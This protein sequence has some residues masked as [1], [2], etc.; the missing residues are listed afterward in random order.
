MN[1]TQPCGPTVS[2]E[3]RRAYRSGKQSSRNQLS[4]SHRSRS[5]CSGVSS[6]GLLGGSVVHG[7][8][9]WYI[10]SKRTAHTAS[11]SVVIIANV[12]LHLDVIGVTEADILARAVRI[13]F[14]PRRRDGQIC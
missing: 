1:K 2:I 8:T 7:F 9:M 13:K 3:P 10:C 6:S 14:D 4:K 5:T 11:T 12:E